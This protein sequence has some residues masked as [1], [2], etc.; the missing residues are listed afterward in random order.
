MCGSVVVVAVFVILAVVVVMFRLLIYKPHPQGIV[1]NRL[2]S[3]FANCL[4][5]HMKRCELALCFYPRSIDFV[6][7]IVL[8]RFVLLFVCRFAFVVSHE[9]TV[10]SIMKQLIFQTTSGI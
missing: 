5:I 1:F 2:A 6:F 8:A 10:S 7:Y 9:A 3:G 4:P